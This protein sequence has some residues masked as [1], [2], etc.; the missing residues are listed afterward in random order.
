[1][2]PF[3][4]ATQKRFSKS[5]RPTTAFSDFAGKIHFKGKVGHALAMEIPRQFYKHNGNIFLSLRQEDAQKSS[6]VRGDYFRATGKVEENYR[7]K[8]RHKAFQKLRVPNRRKSLER[9]AQ[10]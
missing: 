4:E 1:L 8:K 5:Y 9:N 6:L 10:A 3:R 7:P 2:D